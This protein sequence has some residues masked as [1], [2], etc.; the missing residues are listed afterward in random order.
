MEQVGA[1]GRHLQSL[2]PLR[3]LAA[4]WVVLYHDSH[5]YFPNLHPENVTNLLDKGYLAVDLLFMLSGFMM[6]HVH[7]GTFA[8][9]SASGYWD[10]LK[11]RIARL[12]PLH[13]VILFLFLANAGR[14]SAA[15]NTRPLVWLGDISYSLYLVHGFVQYLTTKLLLQG[16]GIRDRED[17]AGGWSLGLFV[18]MVTVSLLLASMSY[19]HVEVAGRHYMR[20]LF[21]IRRPRRQAGV[22]G[23]ETPIVSVDPPAGRGR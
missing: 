20:R 5:Q 22:F 13:L 8:R 9:E 1:A 12:Y 3:G 10:F 6:T 15:L 4:L 2:T 11:A 23:P 16:F 17:L 21:D 19:R 18:A 14:V 7:H